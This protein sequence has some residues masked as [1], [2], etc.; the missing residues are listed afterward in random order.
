MLRKKYEK[1]NSCGLPS[2]IY[3]LTPCQTE[4][5]NFFPWPHSLLYS[6]S[7]LKN[8]KV[9]DRDSF[10]SSRLEVFFKNVFLKNV[11]KHMYQSLFLNKIPG[12]VSDTTL[13]KKRLWHKCFS[14]TFANFLSK[15]TF[16]YWVLSVAASEF[17]NFW[18][19]LEKSLICPDLAKSSKNPRSLDSLD[20]LT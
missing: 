14:V 18:R 2:E 5:N 16:P 13:F 17:W 7:T 8:V 19:S 10:W 15:N 4:T 20:T 9:D 12:W 6:F 11:Q 1:K 3:F